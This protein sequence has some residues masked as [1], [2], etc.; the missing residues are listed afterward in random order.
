MHVMITRLAFDSADAA[1]AEE[2]ELEARAETISAL[3]GFRVLLVIRTGP[4]TLSIVRGFD[5]PER[6][7]RSLA[8]PLRPDL[9]AH[10]VSPPQR[11]TGDVTVA[12]LKARPSR[13][14]EVIAERGT[15]RS[16][17]PRR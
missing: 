9:A 16:K 12:R 5:S 1:R 8:G 2:V 11:E 10:F 17:R 13:S 14:P 7:A 4:M 15:S 3:D 6:I